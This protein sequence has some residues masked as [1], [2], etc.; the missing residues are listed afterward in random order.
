MREAKTVVGKGGVSR[1]RLRAV[2]LIKSYFSGNF[3]GA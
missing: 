2:L 1:G 3:T